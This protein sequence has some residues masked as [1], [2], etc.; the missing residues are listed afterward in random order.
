MLKKNI[1][2]SIYSAADERD[3]REVMAV[4]KETRDSRMMYA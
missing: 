1:Y 2:I 4:E 3:E